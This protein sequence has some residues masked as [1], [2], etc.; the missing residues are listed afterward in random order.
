MGAVSNGF[1]V[2]AL[3]RSDSPCEQRWQTA[4]HTAVERNDFEM[5]ELLITLGADPSIE[6]ARFHATPKGWAEHFGNADLAALLT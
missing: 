4:L 6:D 2:N 1:D 5:I 3:G